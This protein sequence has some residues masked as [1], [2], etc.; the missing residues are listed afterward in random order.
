MMSKS[1]LN[2]IVTTASRIF[3]GF[4]ASGIVRANN[5]N[6]LKEYSL[7][8]AKALINQVTGLE[9]GEVPFPHGIFPDDE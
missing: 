6:K 4:C 1:E 8:S 2:F 9:G 7:K 3:A 5:A